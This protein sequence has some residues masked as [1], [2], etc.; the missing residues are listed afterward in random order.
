M[1]K[2]FIIDRHSVDAGQ[3]G[4]CIV[5]FDKSYLK[6]KVTYTTNDSLGLALNNLNIAGNTETI[7]ANGIKKTT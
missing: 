5:R 4:N 7:S 2:D 6:N 1:D 3:Y